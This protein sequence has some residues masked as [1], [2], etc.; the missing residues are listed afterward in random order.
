MNRSVKISV[1][2]LAFCLLI[3]SNSVSAQAQE[4]MDNLEVNSEE[5]ELGGYGKKGGK[6]KGKGGGGYSGKKGG[7]YSGKKGYHRVLA[8]D[9][10]DEE[11]MDNLAHD[12]LLDYDEEEEEEVD[13]F[14]R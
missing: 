10:D 5:R 3:S 12:P 11:E 7:G 2:L 13:L 9:I 8:P 6:G 1:L 14:E 4:E